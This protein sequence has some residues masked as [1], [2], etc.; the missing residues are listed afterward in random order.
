M[1]GLGVREEGEGEKES[2]LYRTAASWHMTPPPAPPTIA[3]DAD[4]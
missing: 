1:I 2:S 3:G 4:V